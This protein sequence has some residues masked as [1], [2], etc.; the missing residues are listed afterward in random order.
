[1]LC[2]KYDTTMDNIS[3]VRLCNNASKETREV[4]VK[5]LMKSQR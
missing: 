3:K 4:W 2:G 1:M 5:W